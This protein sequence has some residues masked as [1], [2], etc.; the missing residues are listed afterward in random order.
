MTHLSDEAI[1]RQLV[2]ALPPEEASG[3]QA[4]LD[5]CEACRDRG[6]ALLKERER[7]QREAYAQA[8]DRRKAELSRR[9]R[10]AEDTM[11]WWG[12]LVLGAVVAALA[13]AGGLARN[14]FGTSARAAAPTVEVRRDAGGHLGAWV[15]GNGA[16]YLLL[17]TRPAQ[18]PWTVAW[19]LDAPTSGPLA[20][21]GHTTPALPAD[22]AEVLAVFSRAPLSRAEV[23]EALQRDSALAVVPDGW[24][25]RVPVDAR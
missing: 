23:L 16:P 9:R 2:A 18:G 21:R 24:V 15:H 6:R 1:E 20:S 25:V 11:S 22:A 5:G 4:H 13:S 10:D 12:L 8:V 7:A 14:V 17:Y 19:P 3:A